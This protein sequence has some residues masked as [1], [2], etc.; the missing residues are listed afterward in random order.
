MTFDKYVSGAWVEAEDVKRYSSSA[1]TDCSS[2]KRYASSA[3]QEVWNNAP[4]I[5]AGNNCTVT[6]SAVSVHFTWGS[7][8]GNAGGFYIYGNFVKGTYYD[9]NIAYTF[10]GSSNS[11]SM[12]GYVGDDSTSIQSFTVASNVQSSNTSSF[13]ASKTFDHISFTIG[14]SGSNGGSVTWNIKSI[15]INGVE[16]NRRLT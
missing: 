10:S 6:D 9:V 13:T 3:W 14:S 4:R 5:V 8:S 7:T 11:V 16:C 2:A 12:R 1:W 15:K